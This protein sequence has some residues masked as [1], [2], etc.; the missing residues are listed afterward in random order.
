VRRGRKTPPWRKRG[1]VG[2]GDR[3][4]GL[5]ATDSPASLLRGT[6][7][8][9]KGAARRGTGRPPP[10]RRPRRREGDAAGAAA[11]LDPACWHWR[12]AARRPR[13]PACPRRGRRCRRLHS[14]AGAPRAHRAGCYLL[15]RGQA[16]APTRRATVGCALSVVGRVVLRVVLFY[17]SFLAMVFQHS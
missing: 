12:G 6:P 2:G 1:G 13:L 10:S 3:R 16:A 8:R 9:C 11:A 15:T 5:D 7:C 17:L 4:V 14:L